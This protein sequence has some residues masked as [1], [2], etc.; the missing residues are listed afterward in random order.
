[1]GGR[2][3]LSHKQTYFQQRE[4]DAQSKGHLDNYALQARVTELLLRFTSELGISS[5]KA[6][7]FLT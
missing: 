7:V 6:D 5:I 3:F 2:A 4:T 1:M